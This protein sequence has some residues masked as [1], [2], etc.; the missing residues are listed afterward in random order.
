MT[1]NPELQIFADTLII[2]ELF[3]DKFIKQAEGGFVP[4]LINSVENYVSGHIDPN[5][6]TE[7]V[8]NLLAPGILF[9]SGMPWWLI[10]VYEIADKLF[11][12]NFGTIFSSIKSGISSLISGGKQTDSGS[13][14]SVIKT[15][16]SPFWSDS[17]EANDKHA[18]TMR[19]AQL[20]KIALSSFVS[21]YPDFYNHK[22]A[23]SQSYAQL[24]GL[25]KNK[26][27][28]V[29]FAALTWIVVALLA[30]AGFM[31]AGDVIHN[32]LGNKTKTP[33]PSTTPSAIDSSFALNV[34]P[35][36][37]S[38]NFNNGLSSW[39][40]PGNVN[41]LDSTFVSWAVE[42][43]PQLKGYEN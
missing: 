14:G 33:T 22:T 23:G 36:Y 27:G 24:L 20:F 9:A 4:G 41:S 32:L 40:L 13:V 43:Y 19:D 42:I 30:T 15:A 17:S 28:N 6:K 12:I 31:V 21:K 38:E 3:K 34:N 8:I 1:L 7:S 25:T 11:E 29:L 39:T 18:V 2:E 26:T 5:N 10:G 16:L 35:E 37:S